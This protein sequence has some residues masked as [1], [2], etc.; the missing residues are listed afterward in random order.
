MV[1]RRQF[2]AHSSA[3][4]VSSSLLNLAAASS[5]QAETLP[6]Y[7]A[8]VCIL[9]AGGNDSFNMLVPND[10]DQYAEYSAIRSDLALP[11]ADLLALPG[12][13]GNG[14]SHA[15]HPGMPEL[16]SL[17]ADGHAAFVA[18]VGTLLEPVDAAAVE[19]GAPVPVGLYSH[20]DQIQHWQTAT[21]DLRS[22]EGWGGRLADLMSNVN[23]DNGLSMNISLG[24]TNVFQSGVLTSEYSINPG[25][26]ASSGVNAYGEDSDFGRLRQRMID[27]MLAVTHASTFRQEYAKRLRGAIDNQ[28]LFTEALAN[29]TP[30][31]ATFSDN[32]LSQ[33]LRQI[34]RVIGARTGLGACRQTFFVL[35][36][37]W[38]HHDDVLDNQAVMLPW[39]SQGLAEFRNALTDLGLLDQVAT[40]T[41]SDF[42]RTLTS[43]GKGSDHGWGGH[44]IIMGGGVDGGRIF[45]SYPEISATSP[46][47][48]GRGR[49]V[50]TT[51]TDVYFAELALW[52][53]VAASDLSLVLPNVD[54]FYSPGSGAP[55]GMLL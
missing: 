6:D 29:G 22:A 36:G 40:F 23:A 16:Q 35:V 17:Y 2:I 47:D 18:N 31:S 38:D 32:P 49:Y 3:L 54:R 8:M 42:G 19:A 52:F 4:T 33:S 1:S 30:V 45:G 39:V 46:L 5:V 53:G 48:T 44:Q 51:S 37:G 12:T 10:P 7:K 15:L 26:N 43:N 55:M 9:L 27:D 13:D 14:R 41:I 28:A 24:G 34:A 20:S 11:S 25:D 50:P 21:P